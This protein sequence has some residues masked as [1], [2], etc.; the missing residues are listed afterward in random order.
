MYRCSTITGTRTVCL[1]VCLVDVAKRVN[2][3]NN[4]LFCSWMTVDI[5]T[6]SSYAAGHVLP[7]GHGGAG[8]G[9]AMGSDGRNMDPVCSE[10]T[11]LCTLFGHLF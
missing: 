6:D 2:S 3:S 8:G 7:R 4:G 9:A 10:V 5:S 11:G 1:F